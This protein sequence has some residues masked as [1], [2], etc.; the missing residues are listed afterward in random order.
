MLEAILEL[1]ADLVFSCFGPLV[2][3]FVWWIIL[4][5]I[6]WV[7][8]TPV[9]VILA[10]FSAAP[11]WSSVGELFSTLTKMWSDWGLRFLPGAIKTNQ[12]LHL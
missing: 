5:P 7:L 12:S 4:L 10:I 8:S 6:L 2:L 11:Y 1:L 3:G 9:V